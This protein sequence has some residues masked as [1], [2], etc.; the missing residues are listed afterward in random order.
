MNN[1]KITIDFIGIGAGR[2]G[3]IWIL[4]A[5]GEHPEICFPYKKELNYFSSPRPEGG[6]SEYEK[7]GINGYLKLFKSCQGKIKGEFSS[8]YMPDLKVAKI[9]KKN[10]P[11]IKIWACIREPVERAFSDYVRGKEFHL[12][13]NEDFETAFKAKKNKLYKEGDGYR[14]RGFYYK[15]LKPYFDLFPRKNIKVILFEDFKKDNKKVI[16]ELYKFL[17]VDPNFTPSIIGKR[18]NERTGAKF[19]SLRAFISFLAK[20]SHKLERSSIGNIIFA[21][22]RETKIDEFFNKLNEKNTKKIAENEIL[23]I[24]LH[25]K[26]KKFYS[27]D[28]KKLEELI[29]RDLNLWK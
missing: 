11:D 23:N 28:I 4:N 14:E 16:K 1:Q 2:S 20:M 21:F 15:Q 10:F 19:K 12:K 9:I 26:L 22:K 3:T 24:E 6:P 27:E 5:L 7:R 8:H 29:K 18:I 13:E 17:G 25:K